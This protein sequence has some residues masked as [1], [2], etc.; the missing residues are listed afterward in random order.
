MQIITNTDLKGLKLVARGKVRDIYDLDDALLFVATDRLSAF[1]VIL[2]NGIPYKGY[3]LTQVSKYWFGATSSIV[4]NHLITTNIDEMPAAVR[5]YKDILDGRTMLVKKAQTF[6][7]ECIARGY[8][9]GSGLKDYKKTGAICGIS[10]PAGL[11]ESQKLAE[12]IFTPATKEE[13]GAHDEN[14]SFERMKSI[15]GEAD[16]EKLKAITLKLYATAAELAL[17]KGI[18]IADT[19]FEFGK[20]NGEIILIDEAL[21]PDSSRFWRQAAYK[22][23]VSQDSMDKQPVRD[24]LETLGWDKTPP[25]PELPQEIVEKTAARYKEIMEILVK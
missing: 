4:S 7:V 25:A 14:I 6:P 17:K 23:G 13:V 10:L 2:P 12:P 5:P 21:T 19:K 8:I 16:A 24:Y 9:T 3:V 11:V 22:V 15:V 1:D 20:V 18:I